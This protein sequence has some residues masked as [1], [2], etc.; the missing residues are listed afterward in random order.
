[1]KQLVLPTLL[2]LSMLWGCTNIGDLEGLSAE[3]DPEFAIPLINTEASLESLLE[4]FDDYTFLDV[5]QEGVILLRYKGD[6]VTRTSEDIFANIETALSAAFPVTD[7]VWSLPFTT[8]DGIEMDYVELKSGELNYTFQSPHEENVTVQ[9][10]FPQV[11]D[12]NGNMLQF[13][14][15][16]LYQGTTPVFP[17][18]PITNVDLT[19]H[20]LVANEDGNL[21]I[22]YEAIRTDG[23][24]DTLINFFVTLN[25]VEFSYAEGYFGNQMHDGERDTINIEFF[26]NWTRGDVFFTDPKITIQVINSFGVPT[27][28]IVNVFDVYT[29]DGE[30]LSLNN[31]D[32]TNG[33]DFEYP[34]LDEVGI[35]KVTSY[36]FTAQN[37]NIDTVL[38]SGPIAIDYDVDAITNPDGNEAIRGFMTD[39]SRYT[40]SVEV[41]LPI[42]GQATGFAALDT[43]EV[44]FTQFDR[45]EEVE[46]KLIAE[47]ELPLD[48]GLQLYFMN[49]EGSLVDS[50]LTDAQQV[51]EAAPVNAN[52]IATEI[53]RSER[54][55]PFDAARFD[56]IKNSSFIVLNAAF[57]TFNEGNVPVKVLADQ[58]VGLKMGMK[59]KLEGEE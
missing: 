56:A 40:V 46:F 42:Y 15:V 33:I 8:P 17:F 16:C 4:N 19:G 49:E 41:E 34:E 18:P 11:L 1:M 39:E 53:Q 28:S 23:T 20:S 9:V 43:F 30:V 6:V 50:L 25:D 5:D 35:E 12:P 51:I 10:R 22:E 3:T 31:A 21:N 45:V 36:T 7:T 24:R 55:I 57:S 27:R 14:H 13:S 37:S 29:V 52:S 59:I 47:N 58:G 2:L 48:I 38:G 44:D 54:I 32:L 26:E